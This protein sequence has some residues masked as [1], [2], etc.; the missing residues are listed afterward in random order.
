MNLNSLTDTHFHLSLDDDIDN[1]LKKAKEN[2][3]N[4][5]ILSGCELKGIEESLEIIKKKVL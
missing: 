4:N 5:F 2:N 3:V 1:I